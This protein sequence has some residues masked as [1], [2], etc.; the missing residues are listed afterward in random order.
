MRCINVHEHWTQIYSYKCTWYSRN[1]RVRARALSNM[2][3]AILSVSFQFY[4]PPATN[5][6][7]H[8]ISHFIIWFC[9]ILFSIRQT[10]PNRKT[11]GQM[12]RKKT[13]CYSR[14]CPLRNRD[15][16]AGEREVERRNHT[17]TTTVCVMKRSVYWC[18]LYFICHQMNSIRAVSAAESQQHLYIYNTMHK[19]T[20]TRSHHTPERMWIGKKQN[21]CT[22]MYKKSISIKGSCI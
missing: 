1:I 10:K 12:E 16:V 20:L 11:L 2:Y 22:R 8:E 5:A 15:E 17:P 19:H 4:Q 3:W 9:R 14:L 7:T 18:E 21:T 13:K 6:N